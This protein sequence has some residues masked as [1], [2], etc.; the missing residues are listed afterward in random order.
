MVDIYLATCEIKTKNIDSFL[1]N[2]FLG[3]AFQMLEVS[4]DQNNHNVFFMITTS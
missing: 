1:V 4:I 2:I 3:I